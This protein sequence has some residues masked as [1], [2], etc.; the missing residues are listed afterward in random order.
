MSSHSIKN[1]I[2]LATRFRV[3]IESCDP[4]QLFVTLQRFPAGA[5]G[6]ASYLL[7]RYLKQN[8]CGEFEYVAGT[9]S[10]QCSHAWLEQDGV[11]IDITADQFEGIDSAVIVTTD[12][13]WYSSFEEDEECRHLA[14]FERYTDAGLVHALRASYGNITDNIIRKS[15]HT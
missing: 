4:G 15:L 10:T 8:G 6:D 13:T 2:N 1:L 11:I 5:C 9:D 14:D 3:G 12:R 7:A